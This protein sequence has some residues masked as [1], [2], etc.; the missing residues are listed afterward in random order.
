MV[1]RGASER[2]RGL[3]RRDDGG[4]YPLGDIHREVIGY[5]AR[6]YERSKSTSILAVN[7]N[8]YA[9]NFVFRITH[10]DETR[11]PKYGISEV[12]WTRFL[13]KDKRMALRRE[14]QSLLV[15]FNSEEVL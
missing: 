4:C 15:I 8:A 9:F 14:P 13:R 7:L 11:R 6:V 2:M 5:V 10:A 12:L 1:T 3:W